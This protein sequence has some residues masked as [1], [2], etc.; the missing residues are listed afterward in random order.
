MLSK[1]FYFKWL[2][3]QPVIWWWQSWKYNVILFH[4]QY[5][6]DIPW[7]FLPILYRFTVVLSKPK[8]PLHHILPFAYSIYSYPF[9]LSLLQEKTVSPLYTL[10]PSEYLWFRVQGCLKTR[11]EINTTLV[12]WVQVL[13]HFFPDS[14]MAT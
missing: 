5:C 10:I 11:K 1:I 2:C 6:Y 13:L 14:S 9:P 3:L 12:V 8:V 7:N 4:F